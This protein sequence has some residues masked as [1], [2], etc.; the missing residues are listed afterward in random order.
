MT[1]RNKITSSIIKAAFALLLAASPAFAMQGHGVRAVEQFA[2]A[3]VASRDVIVYQGQAV[4]ELLAATGLETSGRG[5]RAH[6]RTATPAATVI[7]ILTYN[8]ASNARVA[9][10]G[11]AGV[12][13]TIGAG[14]SALWL[15]GADRTEWVYDVESYSLADPDDVI[16]THRGKFIVYGNRT[17]E[18][19]VTPS[20]QM[21]SG[22]GRYVRFDTDAQGLS[23]AQ[24]LAA[25]TNI[26]AG[27]GGGGAGTW[28]SITGTLTDQTDLVT[29]LGL[30][31]PLASPTLTGTPAAPTAA[32]GTSTT[33]IA[34]T[35]FVGGEITTHA[36][37]TDPH[38]DRA[39]ATSAV[40]THSALTTGAHGITAAGAALLD[41]AD[42]AAQRTT[43][44]LGTAATQASSAFEASGAVSTH[45]GVTTAHGISAYGATLVDD[46]DAATARSTLGLGTAATTAATD[47]ATAGHNHSGV[48]QPSDA[49][50]TAI[51]GLTS[52][53]DSAPYFTGSGTAAL[54]TVTS[55]GRAL[56]DDADASAQ[57]TTLGLTAL[58][59][60]TPGTGVATALGTNVGS[61][62]AVV[63]N[64]GALGTP[65]S[66]TLTN[67][68]GLPPAAIT[69]SGATSNQVL[70][71]NGSAWAPA[72][73][74]AGSGDVVGPSSATDNAIARFDTTTG[75]LVQNSAI[76]V[77][78]ASG[79]S[80][81]LS[82]TA[83]NAL[84]IAAT[85][86]AATTGA[87]VAGVAA[88]L[89]AGPAVA[90]TDTAGAAAGGSVTITAG[91]A[92]RLTSGNADGGNINLVPG[93][94]I[95]TGVSGQVFGPLGTVARPGFSFT[96]D[97][98]TGVYS[99]GANQLTLVQNGTARVSILS[100]GITTF[101]G[102][103]AFDQQAI[104]GLYAN[105]LGVVGAT[106]S[107][108][109]AADSYRTI[110]N[111]SASTGLLTVN[112]PAAAINIQFT[113]ICM[114]TDGIKIVAATG[115]EIRV[116]DKVTATA[117]YIQSTTIGSVVALVAID[118]TTWVATS[119]HGVWTDG[120]FTYD[121]TSLTTP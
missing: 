78:D 92:A 95:G 41:D 42:A 108:Q 5:L 63:T 87:S 112:L 18:S 83:G 68:T 50:L 71:W 11:S 120:T 62:G 109:G 4:N 65:S 88:S 99:P 44:G 113:F 22:D 33:Q 17:R 7:Q 2:F 93:A 51:A 32:G 56:I 69:Q 10:D 39:F 101:G 16:V 89:T 70:A 23:D 12:R 45:N 103:G 64:G 46:A 61:A 52:A 54:M 97:S 86:P 58:A 31:A 91:A 48:Y 118:S 104:T 74:S 14:V 20:A 73:P 13:M 24:K 29:A 53:A 28:G 105:V 38:G 34:T 72:T 15:V 85:A 110:Y 77:G 1:M 79:S 107:N 55:A 37:A 90:S 100:S 21:P 25:R 59:T 94:G 82:S 84:A 117:G 8:G 27:T 80:V 115:D 116:I 96:G 106:T 19:D 40:S 57:R 30:K 49:E 114:D 76:T 6:I 121:D 60:T 26:G 36:S 119:V 81:T 67:A 66:G 75:K 9:F 3:A 98:D 43:L 102:G 47:Y 111:T 35:A